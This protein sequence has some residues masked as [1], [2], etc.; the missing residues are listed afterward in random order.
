M[1]SH[2][3]EGTVSDWEGKTLLSTLPGSRRGAVER[4]LSSEGTFHLQEGM[5]HA[6]GISFRFPAWGWRIVLVGPPVVW[7]VEMG[8]SELGLLLPAVLVMGAAFVGVVFMILRSNLQLPIGSLLGDLAA[9]RRVAPTGIRELDTIGEATNGSMD[10]LRAKAAQVQALHDVAMSVHGKPPDEAVRT[11]LENVGGYLGAVCSA[12]VLYGP[13]GEAQKVISVGSLPGG[14]PVPGRGDLPL[15]GAPEGPPSLA[16]RVVRNRAE[17]EFVAYPL[18]S[19]E[20]LSA[21]GVLLFGGKTGGFTEEDDTLLRAVA[22]DTALALAKAARIAE[23]N[24][25]QRVIDSAFDLVLLFDEKGR[26]SYANPACEGITGYRAEELAGREASGVAGAS[27]DGATLDS[28][29]R[30]LRPGS[31]WRGTLSGRRKDGEPFHTSALVFSLKESEPLTYACIQRDV[32]E[33]RKLY[34]HLLRSQKL[35]AMGTL[36]GGIAHDFNNILAAVLGYADLLVSSPE[37][38]ARVREYS[39]TIYNA[40]NQ[41]AELARKLLASTRKEA[42]RFERVDLNAVVGDSL[43]LL[44][45]SIPKNIE[46]TARLGHDVPPVEGDP[47]QLQQVIVNLAVNARDAMPSGGRLVIATEAG[48]GGNVGAAGITS[49]GRRWVRLTVSDTGVGMDEQTRGKIFDPF[50]TTK[51]KGTGLG[52]ALA[53]KVADAHGGTLA[54]DDRE[55]GGTIARLVVPREEPAP[56]EAGEG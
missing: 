52:L 7:L 42:V 20:A 1:A 5:I 23:L 28:I 41:G 34:D 50:F 31:A 16:G 11:I 53:K 8:R 10:R 36:A 39:R 51:E 17:E 26:V 56:V 38:P 46:V 45:R 21:P 37:D 13:E 14:V 6:N 29:R 35:E 19:G 55:G 40:A 9:G 18:P 33:E 24:R 43:T 49:P 12:L 3:L 47:S 54:L 4:H 2:R 30:T 32:S 27:P 15:A 48:T 22:A 25:F 44:S